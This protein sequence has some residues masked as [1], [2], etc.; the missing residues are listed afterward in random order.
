MGTERFFPTVEWL[1][2]EADHSPPTTSE[3]KKMRVYKYTPHTPSKLYL[4]T[5]FLYFID[6]CC[7]VFSFFTCADILIGLWALKFARK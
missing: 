3:V 7:H 5:L 1:G 6:T 2:R 4:F